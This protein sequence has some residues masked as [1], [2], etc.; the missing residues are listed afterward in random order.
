MP[1][2]VM[3]LLGYVNGYLVSSRMSRWQEN[4]DDGL[5]PTEASIVNK[6]RRH[7]PINMKPVRVSLNKGT[8]N[9]DEHYLLIFFV[10]SL[11]PV[12]TSVVVG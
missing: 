11:T 9:E 4:C 6:L 3:Y 8:R 1:M 7:T 12:V 5:T 10:V 2:L